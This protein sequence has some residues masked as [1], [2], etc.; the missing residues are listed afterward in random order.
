MDLGPLVRDVFGET[1]VAPTRKRSAAKATRVEKYIL[2]IKQVTR[3]G[4][5]ILGGYDDVQSRTSQ[6]DSASQFISR[7]A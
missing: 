6:S 3:K 1:G 2:K 7:E 5:Q 4:G